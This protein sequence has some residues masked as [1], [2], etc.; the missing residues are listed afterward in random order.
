VPERPGTAPPVK[1]PDGWEDFA[2]E[3]TTTPAPEDSMARMTHAAAA[4][5]KMAKP[6]PIDQSDIDSLT[7][8]LADDDAARGLAA[9]LQH[10]LPHEPVLVGVLRAKVLPDIQRLPVGELL[11]K[12][13]MARTS[14]SNPGS[15]VF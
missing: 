14:V 10:V 2:D 15:T 1:T 11:R 12:Q 8:A 7:T 9:A 4:I 5:R 6:G 3:L 13:S